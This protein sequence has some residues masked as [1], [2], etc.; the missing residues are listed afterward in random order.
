MIFERPGQPDVSIFLIGQ[1]VV[2]KKV[3]RGLP[4]DIFGIALPLE[5]DAQGVEP[6]RKRLSVGMRVHDLQALFG[7][8]KLSVPY[9]FKGFRAEYAVSGRGG[10]FGRFTFIDG[11]LCEFADGGR[12]LLREI[13]GSG[14]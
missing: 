12:T 4:T 6:I 8:P 10:S 5:T 9:N 1:R 7:A 3:G 2:A 14:C 13:L 11:V